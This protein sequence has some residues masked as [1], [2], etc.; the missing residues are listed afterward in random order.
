MGGVLSWFKSL[1]FK[2][3]AGADAIEQLEYK[4]KTIFYSKG[5]SLINR[6]VKDGVYE[7]EVTKALL[8]SLEGKNEPIVLDVGA[9]IGLISINILEVLP[10]CKI[11]AFEPGPHQNSLF[12][13]TIE[14]NQLKNI[15]LSALALS[16]E[17]GS[18]SFHVHSTEDASGDGFFD[19]GRAGKTKKINVETTILDSWWKIKNQPKVDLIKMDTEGAE[20]FILEGGKELL[21][22][23]K[24]DLCLEIYEL[25]LRN[26]PYTANDIFDALKNMN[27]QLFTLN[28]Q[29]ITKSNLEAILKVNDT[30]IAK[31]AKKVK[32]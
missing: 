1:T 21:E 26:Y 12:S 19:T 30:F 27:Y 25:N 23:C 14:Y 7:P 17:I 9:N 6:I 31:S 18:A 15:E 3:R 13:K 2:K 10:N 8:L 29:L 24:P 16:N 22:T 4:G 32:F 5:T 28:L 11:Y 20:L